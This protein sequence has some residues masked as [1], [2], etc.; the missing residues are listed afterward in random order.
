MALRRGIGLWPVVV[1]CLLA[2][3]LLVLATLEILLL[4]LVFVPLPRR[5]LLATASVLATSWSTPALAVPALLGFLAV[6]AVWRSRVRWAGWIALTTSTAALLCAL[7]PYAAA[8]RTA[9]AHGQGLSLVDQFGG[10]NYAL[11]PDRTRS[12]VYA[13]VGRHRL[14]MDLW[15]PDGAPRKPRPAVVWVHGGGWESGHRSQTPRWNRWLN[16]RGYTVFDIEYRLAPRATQLQQISDVKCAIGWVRRNARSYAVDPARIVLAGTSAGGNLALSA[17]YTARD[18]RP[19]ASCRTAR[20][21]SVQAVVSF[22]GPTDMAGLIAGGANPA[23]PAVRRFMGGSYRS[24]SDSFRLGS[25]AQ[26]V[27]A[28]VPPT[29]L[30]HGSHDRLVPVEQARELDARLSTAGAVHAYVE[31]PWADHAFDYNWGNWGTQIARPALARFL[32]LHAHP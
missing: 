8:W 5:P 9:R 32:E 14:K 22:Y 3:V 24:A 25:P 16:D 31:I 11:G 13:R 26:L 7:A 29:L 17:A 4:V 19:R 23:D 6:R 27:R 10:L 1:R 20:D 2:V 21:T 28:D 12:L 30:L 15:L 18:D